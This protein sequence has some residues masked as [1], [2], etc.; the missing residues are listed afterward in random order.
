MCDENKKYSKDAETAREYYNSK[1]AYN[2]YYHVW[3]GEDEHLGIYIS[4]DDDIFT[5]SR[6]TI[7]EMSALADIDENTRII[8]L[9][10]G[11]AGSARYLAKKF[12]CH[13]TVL[14]IS[15]AENERG[16]KM[17][18]DQGLDHLIDIVDGNFEN[19]PFDNES[20]D[21]VWSQDAILHSSYRG[22]VI[23]EAVRVL[24]PG[25][26]L[27]FTDPMQTGNCDEKE[28]EPVYRRLNL[29]SLGSP[30]FYEKAC[31]EQGLQKLRFIDLQYHL[32][33]HY[34]TVLELT[35]EKEESLKKDVSGEYLSNMKTGLGHW[36]DGGKKG[37]LTWGIFHFNKPK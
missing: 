27:I 3:G 5:A 28:L 26:D 23:E 6:R 22:K 8:D 17:N 36:I 2:F 16:R 14:N 24:K 29:S 25:G 7:R 33:K 21:I 11:F 30:E 1:D 19:I 13:V 31:R 32:V 20:F 9:G 15:E 37:N 4:P 12:G 10:G 18:K 35:R 34:S